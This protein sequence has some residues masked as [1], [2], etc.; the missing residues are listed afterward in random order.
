MPTWKT[1]GSREPEPRSTGA[2]TT[3]A[4]CWADGGFVPRHGNRTDRRSAQRAS[5]AGQLRRRGA[6]RVSPP[7]DT[8]N[9]GGTP[10]RRAERRRMKCVR[11]NERHP[12]SH[13]K[14][15]RSAPGSTR[16]TFLKPTGGW[17]CVGAVER[18]WTTLWDT[19][20]W[21][22]KASSLDPINGST[23]RLALGTSSARGT[24]GQPS[25]CTNP[26]SAT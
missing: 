18:G 19:T 12:W 20:T 15:H 9:P 8:C 10:T 3:F 23:R 5:G 2:S 16:T 26:S 1:V 21:R 22:A 11:C 25:S 17:R 7:P 24:G 6:S 14:Q 4:D 13:L